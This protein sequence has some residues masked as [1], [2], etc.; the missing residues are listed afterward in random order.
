VSPLDP[1]QG[2]QPRVRSSDD[3]LLGGDVADWGQVV[4]VAEAIERVRQLQLGPAEVLVLE[5]EL[6][7]LG[8]QLEEDVREVC[9]VQL[10]EL[11]WRGP[12][13]VLWRLRDGARPALVPADVDYYPGDVKQIV[14]GPDGRW[15]AVL[16]WWGVQLL[17]VDRSVGRLEEVGNL[18]G[19]RSAS[20]SADGRRIV[21]FKGGRDQPAR[22]WTLADPARGR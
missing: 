7:A 2:G 8:L 15:A 18:E 12:S 3:P 5:L 6:E 1:Q 11:G 9:G 4:E 21:G 13:C 10:L 19:V 16:G 22:L 17:S 20:L 14:F